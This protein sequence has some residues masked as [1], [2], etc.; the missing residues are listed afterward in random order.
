MNK[1]IIATASGTTPALYGVEI[2]ENICQ[3]YGE[4]TAPTAVVTVSNAGEPKTAGGVTL[5]DFVLAVTL[6]Y[7]PCGC[8]S[9]TK[10][11]T[12][13]EKVQV[14]LP[15]AVS[16]ITPTVGTVSVTPTK[17]CNGRARGAKILTS[18]S[19]AYA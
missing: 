13:A 16:T 12:F 7:Q 18:L 14:A 8:S 6:T 2:D 11:K 15:G 17:I 9:E 5:Q 4:G 3:G 19:V 1:I 10:V